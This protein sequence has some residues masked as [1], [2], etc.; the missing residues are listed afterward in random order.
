MLEL[1][2]TRLSVRWIRPADLPVGARFLKQGKP[3]ERW[4]RKISGLRGDKPYDSGIARKVVQHGASSLGNVVP[5]GDH[6]RAKARLSRKES[7]DMLAGCRELARQ[8]MAG[9]LS[10]MLDRIEDD[11]FELA[12]KADGSRI[13]EPLPRRARPGAREARPIEAAFGQHFVEFFN[14]KVRGEADAAQA[15]AASRESFRW[16]ATRI[17]RKPSRCARCRASSRPPAKAS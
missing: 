16:W 17:S 15:A 2:V 7:A 9:A 14:R 10:G 12:E 4:G 5:L 1:G 3:I 13:A 8:R 6:P 11:L